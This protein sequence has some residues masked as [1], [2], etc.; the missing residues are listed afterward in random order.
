MIP[1]KWNFLDAVFDKYNFGPS[2]KKWINTSYKDISSCIKNN[3]TTS[4]QFTLG[5]GVRQGDPLSPY[6]FI[7][8][9]EILSNKIRQN[10][11][12]TG[13]TINNEEIKLQQ[14][15]DDTTGILQNIESAKCFLSEEEKTEGLWLGSNSENRNA[16]L[17]ISWPTKPLR[18]LGV[19][20][21]YNTADCNKYNVEEKINIPAAR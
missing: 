15:A 3:D 21:S 8:A 14:Y 11:D 1:W 10:K 7:L 20:H 12:I 18:I 6:L 5:R 9:V 13:I 2:F 4:K 16:P 19:Y 17:G